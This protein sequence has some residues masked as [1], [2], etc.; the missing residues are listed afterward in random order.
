MLLIVPGAIAGLFTA[1]CGFAG[2]WFAVCHRLICQ[3][4]LVAINRRSL[5]SFCHPQP[6]LSCSSSIGK[7]IVFAQQRSRGPY[8]CS[9]SIS[10]ATLAYL[11]CV[12]LASYLPSVVST[13]C[14]TVPLSLALLLGTQSLLNLDSLRC[15]VWIPR[16]LD[17]SS[18]A[19]A[20]AKCAAPPACSDAARMPRA[21]CQYPVPGLHAKSCSSSPCAINPFALT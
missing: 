17:P 7:A 10:Q 4:S 16:R 13:P 18:I 15:S 5:T 11:L 21:L 1:S 3:P 14:Q 2:C 12:E 9:A 6:H 20:G 19:L 8:R